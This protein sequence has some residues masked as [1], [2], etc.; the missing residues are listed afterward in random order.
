M[1]DPRSVQLV[2]DS[3]RYWVSEMHVDGFRFDLAPTLARE[4]HEVSQRSAFFDIIHQDPVLSQV[5][6]IAEPWD[7]GEDGYQVGNFPAN[8]REWNGQYRDTVRRFWRGDPGQLAGLASRLAGS[9]DL[10]DHSGRGPHASINFVTSHDGFTLRDLVSY[11]HK[12]NEANREDNR[13][14]TNDNYS[15]NC[16]AEGDTDDPSVRTLRV[17]QSRNLLATLYLSQGVPMV[18]HGDEVGRTQRGN[19]NAYCQDNEVSWLSWEWGGEDLELLEW[20][21]RL[22]EF[23]REHP[24]LGQLRFLQGEP[25]REGGLHDLAWLRSDG[26]PMTDADW[27]SHDRRT[28]GMQ[29][30]ASR[31]AAEDESQFEDDVLLALF[32]AEPANVR[33]RLP[34]VPRPLRWVVAFDT[35]RADEPAGRRTYAGHASISVAARSV[36]ALTYS[37][38]A[39]PE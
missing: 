23:R 3:L 2:M 11:D 16:G 26:L 35:A 22:G 34:Q 32:N 36:L 1:L 29:L 12:H 18:L 38:R 5:K 19:N 17:Q 15:W 7:L 13:D 31:P 9:S 28:L 39:V 27:H 21:K 20:V 6:L 14:G 30:A 24:T 25:V 8:W 4:M 37:T 10:Y 33:F